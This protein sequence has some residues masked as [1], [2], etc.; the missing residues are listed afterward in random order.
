[1][2]VRLRERCGRR[3][4]HDGDSWRWTAETGGRVKRRGRALVL[5]LSQKMVSYAV[6]AM[7]CGV[8]A[9]RALAGECFCMEPLLGR[10]LKPRETA[11]RRILSDGA[12]FVNRTRQTQGLCMSR[13]REK[14]SFATI[15]VSDAPV[16]GKESVMEFTSPVAAL[17]ALT[18][19]ALPSPPTSLA[20][21][22]ATAP[23]PRRAA[24]VLYPLAAV[25]AVTALL[26]NHR[27]VLAI[28]AWG[29]RQDPALRTALGFPM[30]HTPC[31]S[32]LQRLVRQLDAA[33]L[34][35]AL[36]V[37]IAPAAT[38]LQGVAIDGKAQRGRLRV[39]AAGGPVH[40][41][42][43]VCHESGLIL[44]H[45][46]ITVAGAKAEAELSVAPAL[47]RRID[48]RDRV[49]TGDALY[50]QRTLCRQV[51]DAGGDY[52]LLVKENQSALH[53]AIA[54][55]FDPAADLA[56]WPLVARRDARSMD[57]G[58]GRHEERR[59]LIASA[60]L[61]GYL[62]WPGAA[63]VFRLER[64]WREHGKRHR[65]LHVGIT[66]FTPCTRTPPD[67]SRCAVATGPSRIPCIA[68][69]T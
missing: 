22:F 26:A 52:L 20:V 63:Q 40:A 61:N 46:P 53:D 58:H 25:L 9:D 29:A 45:E 54:V 67:C 44:A 60:D 19:A 8:M 2:N 35:H 15:G 1:M 31:Q 21:A 13:I 56:A 11:R 28:A 36:S 14:D 17:A 49:L 57:R 38:P 24:N 12:I 65:A 69:R 30:E 48:W 68:T 64:T 55:L 47:L 23:D 66:S 50:C 27:S 10:E 7:P 34:A 42:S 32:T 51:K 43:A 18:I 39:P 4:R 33:A 41:V 37:Q 6:R 16:P 62:D 59:T 5:V 3:N